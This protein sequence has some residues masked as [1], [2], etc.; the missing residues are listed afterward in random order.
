MF[1]P[2]ITTLNQPTLHLRIALTQ[3]FQLPPP[4]SAEGLPV[5]LAEPGPRWSY[6]EEHEYFLGGVHILCTC[7]S[8]YV[9]NII[10]IYMYVRMYIYIYTCNI[11]IYVHIQ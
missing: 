4:R 9:Y 8:M 11:Y 10:Y 3:A 2:Q 5:V 7:I 6:R 1:H